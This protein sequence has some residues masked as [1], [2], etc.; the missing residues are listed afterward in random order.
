M[1]QHPGILLD[2]G[3]QLPVLLNSNANSL[4]WSEEEFGPILSV[5]LQSSSCAWFGTG[6][7]PIISFVGDVL[8]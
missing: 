1:K 4:A 7:T 5:V 6:Q 8:L 2:A 3:T